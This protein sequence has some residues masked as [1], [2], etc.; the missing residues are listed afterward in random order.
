MVIFHSYVCLPEGNFA[1]SG[2]VHPKKWEQTQHDGVQ[3]PASA[4]LGMSRRA[5]RLQSH[6][7]A[8]IAHLS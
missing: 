2:F 1:C 6:E 8:F 4:G 7:H 5:G 3:C